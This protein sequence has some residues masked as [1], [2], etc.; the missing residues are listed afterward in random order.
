[1]WK[2]EF[3]GKPLYKPAIEL[4]KDRVIVISSIEYYDEIR[5]QLENEFGIPPKCMMT[6]EQYLYSIKFYDGKKEIKVSFVGFWDGFDIYHNIFIEILA[7]RHNVVIDE[8][9]PDYIFCSIFGSGFDYLQYN[10]V[11]I[12]F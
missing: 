4:L 5:R 8:R 9:K 2:K 7:K 6:S 10:G 12:F 1:M 11:R 3:L